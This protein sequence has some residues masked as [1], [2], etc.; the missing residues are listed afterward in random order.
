MATRHMASLTAIASIA[1]ATVFTSGDT[2]SCPNQ[3]AGSWSLTSASVTINGSTVL[4]YGNNP[5]GFLINTPA[6]DY[7]FMEE[8]GAR[9]YTP[10]NDFSSAQASAGTYS[11][12]EYGAFATRTTLTSTVPTDVGVSET[13]AI[14]NLTRVGDTLVEILKPT[15]G[16]EVRAVWSKFVPGSTSV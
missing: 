10:G 12:D 13:T 14:F 5:Q 15:D 11:I 9:N 3:I 4:P 16:T 6:P 8:L 1:S 2:T 7:T